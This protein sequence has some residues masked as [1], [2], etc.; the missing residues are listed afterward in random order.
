MA[1][2]SAGLRNKLKVNL[3]PGNKS[4]VFDKSNNKTSNEVKN[5]E[6]A[7]KVRP[8]IIA[9]KRRERSMANKQSG[10]LRIGDLRLSRLSIDESKEIDLTFGGDYGYDLEKTLGNVHH[11]QEIM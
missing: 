8:G 1:G 10:N 5:G 2:M 6:E 7:E 3:L 9:R 11:I 4:S